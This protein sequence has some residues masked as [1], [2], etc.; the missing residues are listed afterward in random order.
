MLEL[1]RDFFNSYLRILKKAYDLKKPYENLEEC[2][3]LCGHFS[4]EL[5]GMIALLEE[6]KC[7]TGEMRRMES[8]RIA[9]AFGTIRLFGAYEEKGEIM[10]F[11]KRDSSMP[12]DPHDF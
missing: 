6:A 3:R 12:E 2:I 8:E 1:Y 5:R 9:E 10:V 11:A 7:I 4:W